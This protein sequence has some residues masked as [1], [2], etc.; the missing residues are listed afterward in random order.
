M[1]IENL[2]VKNKYVELEDVSLDFTQTGIY[3]IKGKNGAG[4]TTLMEE[5]VFGENDIS[6]DSDQIRQVYKENR[7]NLFTY[8]AQN[9]T[10]SRQKVYDYIRKGNETI[11]MESIKFYFDAFQLDLNLLKAHFFTLSGGEKMKVSIISGLLKNTPYIFL[12]EP[13]NNLDNGSVETLKKILEKEAL[14]KRII[15]I[16]HDDRFDFDFRAVYQVERKRVDCI[17]RNQLGVHST[18]LTGGNR[19]PSFLRLAFRLSKNYAQFVTIMIVC[20]FLTFL[21]TY[22]HLY[23]QEHYNDE[24]KDKKANLIYAYMNEPFDSDNL[25]ETYVK[26]ENLNIDEKKYDKGTSYEDI[27]D[28]ANIEGVCDVYL[29]DVE[30]LD[31]LRE[32][33]YFDT[34]KEQLYF[35]ACPQLLYEELYDDHKVGELGIGS[36]DGRGPADDANE[37]AISKELLMD[38]FGYEEHQVENA[39]GETIPLDVDGEVEDYEI[40]GFCYHDIAMIS[41]EKKHNFGYYCYDVKSY[42]DFQNEQVKYAEE[43]DAIDET[44]VAMTDQI[45]I[46]TNQGYERNV[47]NTLFQEY[48]GQRYTSLHYS[49]VWRKTYNGS[50][51]MKIFI[52]NIGI[53][54]LLS[55]ALFFVNRNATKYNLQFIWDYENYYVN[56]RKLQRLYRWI[57]A[58]EYIALC[59]LLFTINCWLS[60]YSFI[61]KYYLITDAAIIFL[62]IIGSCVVKKKG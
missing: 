18:T 12:D 16:S 29:E 30:Y 15:L 59:F 11:T 55:V 54:L 1:R 17:T 23:L 5:I 45:A 33:I 46:V 27:D 3:L 31:L 20:F 56:R 62:P 7:F 42:P 35:Y 47:L 9:V 14:S 58:G 22:T 4:K 61:T 25:N 52:V 26:G 19:C 24:N 37:V 8:I 2:C 51:L 13:S 49:L 60:Q 32:K 28:I 34:A 36:I 38:H 41:Y 50:L 6:F 40:V 57:L 10:D 39:I 53:S 43:V 48:P 44:G 21:T